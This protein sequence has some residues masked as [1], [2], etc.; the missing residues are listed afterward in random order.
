MVEL[1]LSNKEEL[2]QHYLNTTY[3]VFIDDEQYDIKIEQALP[4]QINRLI[5]EDKTAAII[6]A[7]NPRSQKL[8]EAE[9]KTRNSALRSQLKEYTIFNALGQGCD[10]SWPAEE[11]FLVIGIS[12]EQVELVVV[13]FEQNAYIWFEFDQ[14]ASLVFTELW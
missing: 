7:W 3:S 1:M 5:R 12:K 2:K 10:A 8:S 4:Q 14:Q 13:E 9:N 11:S 6:T